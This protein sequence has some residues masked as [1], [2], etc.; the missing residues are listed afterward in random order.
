MDIKQLV[1][2]YKNKYQLTNK[3]VAEQF[4]VTHT[5]VGR[6]LNGTVKTVQQDTIDKMSSVLKC[7]VDALLNGTAVTL[8]K[9]IL[10]VAKAG[11]DLLLED[12]Y[13]GEENITLEEYESGDFFLQVSGNSMIGSGIKDGGL[14]YVKKC[15]T[16]YNGEIAVISVGDEVTIKE[17][18]KDSQGITLIASNPEVD[19]R[20]FTCEEVEEMPVRIVGKVLYAKNYI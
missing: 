14:V 10:G 8:K 9:P 4:G 16:V 19:D 18:R 5:T 3:E 13:L 1:K 11:Y 7:D 17:F 6:W 12:N 20:Y 15:D 2:D